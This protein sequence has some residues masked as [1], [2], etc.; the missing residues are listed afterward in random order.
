MDQSTWAHPRPIHETV[1]VAPSNGLPVGPGSSRITQA[2][3]IGAMSAG[4]TFNGPAIDL[5]D[6]GASFLR[7]GAL[8]AVSVDGVS[9]AG[10][11]IEIQYS[12]D[13]ITAWRRAPGTA[14]HNV[15]AINSSANGQMTILARAMARFARIVF[16]NGSVDQTNLAIVFSAVPGA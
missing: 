4:A 1:P 13:G 10:E 9:S 6:M 8:L 5:H 14:G 12:D 11:S 15:M 16:V 2:N 7:S 3:A